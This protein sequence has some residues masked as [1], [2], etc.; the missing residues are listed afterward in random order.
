MQVNVVSMHGRVCL[1]SMTESFPSSN[2]RFPKLQFCS[3]ITLLPIC[4]AAFVWHVKSSLQRKIHLFIFTKVCC[5]IQW[6]LNENCPSLIGGKKTTWQEFMERKSLNFSYT[7]PDCPE[8]L[9]F[10][11][12]FLDTWIATDCLQVTSTLVH[13]VFNRLCQGD[14]VTRLIGYFLL[15][16]WI[17]GSALL[18]RKAQMNMHH[19]R[20]FRSPPVTTRDKN[21]S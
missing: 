8:I 15:A 7:V 2:L 18:Q 11:T 3:H 4:Q 9:L 1:K 14:N 17:P 6:L 19:D 10:Q 13:V 20:K 12:F 16:L 5:P 21:K